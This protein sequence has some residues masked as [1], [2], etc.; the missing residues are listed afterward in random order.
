[1]IGIIGAMDIEINGLKACMEQIEIETV[2]QIAFCK[3]TV[4][5][6][7]CVIARS[8]VGKVNAAICAQIM[9][10]K[11]EPKA[12]INTGVA[13]GIGQGVCVGDVVISSGLVQHDMDTS[14]L[15]D[16]KGFISGIDLV[17]IPASKK[18]MNLVAEKAKHTYDGA[19]HIGVIATGDQFIGGS[20]Q[21][22]EIAHGFQAIA[23]EMEGA[24]I[25]QVCY[26]NQIDFVAIRAISDNADEKANVSF[27]QFAAKAAE[28][29]TQLLC[30]VLPEL[31]A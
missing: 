14:A 4:K 27:E 26:I 13:G 25:A 21:L 17:T 16:P 6:V 11:Y 31:S 10:M 2:S 12:I 30:Q 23:C 29:S 3:G 19:V 22:R 5:G 15:G 1:M 24:S 8:G 18:M 7:P 9:A 20:E 28:K